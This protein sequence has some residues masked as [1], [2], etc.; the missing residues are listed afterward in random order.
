MKRLV[1]FLFIVFLFAFVFGEYLQDDEKDDILEELRSG[2]ISS[3]SISVI[4]S[5][6]SEGL[7][8]GQQGEFVEAID[9]LGENSDSFWKSF[10]GLSQSDRGDLVNSFGAEKKSELLNVFSNQYIKNGAREKPIV[11][12]NVK[13]DVGVDFVKTK[14]GMEFVKLG[15]K[16][17]YLNSFKRLDLN[18]PTYNFDYDSTTDT[19]VKSTEDGDFSEKTSFSV[20]GGNIIMGHRA[21][22]L[23]GSDGKIDKEHKLSGMKAF[24]NIELDLTG[25]EYKMKLSAIGDSLEKSASSVELKGGIR[26]SSFDESEEDA[27][28]VFDSDGELK[29]VENL[30]MKIGEGRDSVYY[31]ALNGKQRF[32]SDVDELLD[33]EGAIDKDK[34]DK[35]LSEGGEEYD[36]YMVFDSDGGEGGKPFVA[37]VNDN[38]GFGEL[39]TLTHEEL[40]RKKL[41][42][43]GQMFGMDLKE[44]SSGSA[45][46]SLDSK[47]LDEVESAIS[48]LRFGTSESGEAITGAVDATRSIA[49]SALS[50]FGRGQKITEEQLS[51][52][53][54][55]DK[56]L[57]PL[58]GEDYKMSDVDYAVFSNSEFLDSVEGAVQHF[59][60]RLIKDSNY[61]ERY[62]SEGFKWNGGDV[63][64]YKDD[65]NALLGVVRKADTIYD[66]MIPKS[67][68]F[69]NSP[70]G[71]GT[72]LVGG[73]VEVFNG[74][75]RISENLKGVSFGSGVASEGGDFDIFSPIDKVLTSNSNN[76]WEIRENSEGGLEPFLVGSNE[77]IDLV[78]ISQ[79]D[80]KYKITNKD[81]GLLG[82]G[83]DIFSGENIGGREVSPI[84]G[85]LKVSRDDREKLEGALGIVDYHNIEGPYQVVVDFA[86]HSDPS[87]KSLSDEISL[88]GGVKVAEFL[89][90][91]RT[92]IKEI[93]GILNQD[94]LSDPYV[95]ERELNNKIASYSKG[96][97]KVAGSSKGSSGGFGIGDAMIGL[98]SEMP[99]SDLV[100]VGSDLTSKGYSS[101][102]AF[103][104][105]TMREASNILSFMDK[106]IGYVQEEY[107]SVGGLKENRRIS[108]IRKQNGDLFLRNSRGEVLS[109]NSE[110][111]SFAG[112]VVPLLT[113]Y[114]SRYLDNQALSAKNY[115]FK[116]IET[117]VG[118]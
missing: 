90:V 56:A 41:D 80:I 44:E 78:G 58:L 111:E 109:V 87:G 49:R 95:R 55:L 104:D 8:E 62:G 52:R 29:S 3:G 54:Q 101:Y 42:S 88:I 115:K 91:G 17:I 65:L 93:V 20:K 57:R 103:S 33:S 59:K 77:V 89:E 105:D 100:Q 35:L 70:G 74:D 32:V 68:V 79:L 116:K 102:G 28:V 53:A 10:W 114:G 112:Q 16:M 76:V 73:N 48:K 43:I 113:N 67:K 1:V 5:P 72:L 6:G 118:D 94:T 2:K 61:F 23:V 9:S 81:K 64:G 26:I 30:K 96:S 14:S 7:S 69:L 24:G 92:E 38:G 86:K 51:A 85:L 106:S 60:G 63:T 45:L 13:G 108:L 46:A 36:G 19:L 31:E 18:W 75:L 50:M 47:K 84:T 97:N 22:Y 39:G 82:I 83:H 117:L 25:E 98:L 15:E 21:L 107:N 71:I 27:E 37:A 12:F 4:T 11:D 34:M 66:T 40:Q 99:S 110:M